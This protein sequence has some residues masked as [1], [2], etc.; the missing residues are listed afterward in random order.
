MTNFFTLIVC[1]LYHKGKS[2]AFIAKYLRT[3]EDKV[4]AVLQ[5]HYTGESPC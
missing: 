3:S 5:K 4:D 2:P 1:M